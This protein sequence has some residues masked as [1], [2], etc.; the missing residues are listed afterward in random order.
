MNNQTKHTLGPWDSPLPVS[1]PYNDHS[2]QR[3]NARLIAEL[4]EAL[5]HIKAIPSKYDVCPS[6]AMEM[7]EIARNAI[8]KAIGS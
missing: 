1:A 5:E 6:I 3:A 8:N 2:E 7:Y 4:L